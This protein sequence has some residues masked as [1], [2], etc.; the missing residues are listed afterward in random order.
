VDEGLCAEFAALLKEKWA[1]VTDEYVDETG[2]VGNSDL[3]RER[4]CGEAAYSA[5]SPRRRVR[6]SA[7]RV[8]RG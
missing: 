7:L 3:Q 6:I 1:Q 5:A 2:A 4:G 8:G